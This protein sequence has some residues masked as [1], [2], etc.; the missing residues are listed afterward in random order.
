MRRYQNVISIAVV[1]VFTV[2]ITIRFDVSAEQINADHLVSSASSCA[3]PFLP[4]GYRWDYPSANGSESAGTIEVVEGEVGRIVLDGSGYA[5]T[6]PQPPPGVTV[7]GALR[8]SI[9]VPGVGLYAYYQS[10]LNPDRWDSPLVIWLANPREVLSF[11]E[12]GPYSDLSRVVR[13]VDGRIFLEASS[14][15]RSGYAK[16]QWRFDQPCG[17]VGRAD[18]VRFVPDFTG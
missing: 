6:I 18:V 15:T 2:L 9:E 7:P 10:L 13:T 14:S 1:I 12:I 8:G 5:G 4:S 11:E 17:G 16:Y 3:Q